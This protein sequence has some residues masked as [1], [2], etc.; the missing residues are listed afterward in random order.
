MLETT[1]RIDK[2]QFGLNYNDREFQE[3]NW[4]YDT[5]GTSNSNQVGS[6]RTNESN[7]ECLDAEFIHS[8]RVNQCCAAFFDHSKNF[9]YGARRECVDWRRGAN[10]PVVGRDE[11]KGL[12][13]SLC[14]FFWN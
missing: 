13:E 6:Q 1:K 4:C 9:Y 10:R 5:P 8:R 7:F 14:K 3:G 2:K 12:R 11:R